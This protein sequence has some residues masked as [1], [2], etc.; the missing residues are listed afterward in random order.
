[1]EAQIGF[2]TYVRL[3]QLK[4]VFFF[5][6]MVLIL[7]YPNQMEESVRLSISFLSKNQQK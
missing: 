3:I 6:S 5:A 7:V 1:M 4:F 2:I